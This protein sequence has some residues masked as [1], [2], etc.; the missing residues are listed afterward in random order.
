MLMLLKKSNLDEY[1]ARSLSGTAKMPASALGLRRCYLTTG[2]KCLIHKNRK[3]FTKG[4]AL[5]LLEEGDGQM[6]AD[7]DAHCHQ[8]MGYLFDHKGQTLEHNKKYFHAAVTFSNTL[9]LTSSFTASLSSESLVI[10]LAIFSF[11]ISARIDRS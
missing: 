9:A 2:I 5:M 10:R 1:R 3:N 6:L 8:C 4:M 7:S 11:A